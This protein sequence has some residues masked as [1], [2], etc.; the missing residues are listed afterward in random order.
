MGTPIQK[1]RLVSLFLTIL[2]NLL[3]QSELEYEFSEIKAIKQLRK[4]VLE[5]VIEL[6]ECV[7]E[8]D[9]VDVFITIYVYLVDCYNEDKGRNQG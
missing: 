8:A 2:K 4:I 7:N 5:E 3:N 6:I 9:S 1:K